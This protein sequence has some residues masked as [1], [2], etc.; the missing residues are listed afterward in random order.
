M[1]RRL[2]GN[3]AVKIMA[4]EIGAVI[5]YTRLREFE[6]KV[7]DRMA[8]EHPRGGNAREWIMAMAHVITDDGDTRADEG[9][10][11]GIRRIRKAAGG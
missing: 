2:A 1:T 9:F 11:R 7:R 5:G 4:E 8:R 6:R 10:K 3:D